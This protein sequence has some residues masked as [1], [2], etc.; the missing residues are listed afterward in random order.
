MKK[1]EALKILGLSD[2]ATDDEIKKAHREKVIANHPD[3]YTDPTKKAAAEEETKK[4]NEA[5]DVLLSRKWEPEFGR[6]PYANPYGNPFS[7]G[8]PGG[9]P[10]TGAGQGGSGNPQDPFAGGW[11]FGTGGPGWVWTNW[12]DVRGEGRPFDPFNPFGQARAE[13]TPKQKFEDAKK[14]LQSNLRFIGIKFVILAALTIISMFAGGLFLYVILTA[15]YAL[16]KRL[17]SCLIT[18][19]IPLIM[20][21]GPVVTMLVPR[22]GIVT[23]PLLFFF[24]IALILDIRQVITLVQNYRKAKKD[25]SGE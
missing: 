13:K 12:D 6:G 5:R 7:G 8:Y 23:I 18:A 24:L 2:G 21:V 4:I 20:V 15:V 10:G 14:A 9:Y 11:P 16:Y 22:A 3:K 17:G 25:Y 1:S 19:A